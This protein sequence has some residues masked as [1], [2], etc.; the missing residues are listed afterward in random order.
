MNT[1][2]TLTYKHTNTIQERAFTPS[3]GRTLQ[4]AAITPIAHSVLQRCS[5]GVECP[6]CRAKREQQEG[7]LQR[8]AVNTAP[9]SAVPP[10]VHDV[11][12]APGQPLD[13]GTRAF[14]EPRFGHDFSGVRVH[15]DASAAQSARAVNALAYT[16]GRDVVFGTG[17]YMPETIGGKRLLAH[18]L[19]HVAQQ[20]DVNAFEG[21]LTVGSPS[22]HFEQEADAVASQIARNESIN[23]RPSLV[24]VSEPGIQRDLATPQPDEPAP[25]QPDLTDEQ[26][27]K[28]IAF[29]SARYDETNTRFIQRILGGPVKGIWTE[30]NIVAI[31]ATQE[32]YGLVKDGMVGFETFRFLNNE[33]NLEHLSTGTENCLTAFTL[34]GPDT[35]IFRP[36]SPTQCAFEGHFR[37][38]AHFS[39]HCDCSQFEYRQ[40]ISGHILLTRGGTVIGRSNLLDKLPTPL[41]ETFQEDGERKAGTVLRY[42]HREQPADH[43]PEDRYIDDRL[44]DDQAHGCRYKGEDRP[45]AIFNC[46]SGDVYDVELRF[47]GEIQRNGTPIQTKLWTGIQELF[48]VP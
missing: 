10:I 30:E 41:S 3:F 38:A 7:T 20:K 39:S 34:I 31:A 19:T 5:N 13:R 36:V 6:D 16:V 14:M 46:Q 35:P 48:V 18:E 43:H 2:K 24:S 23:I 32:Q 33:A 22:S 40:F 47:R 21:Q 28:A 25:G 9:T 44:A 4:R 12:S 45:N 8:A 26:I 37:V 17:Q 11:L 29:N 27:R 15:T 1:L 42:G